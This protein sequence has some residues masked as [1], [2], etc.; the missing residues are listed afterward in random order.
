MNTMLLKLPAVKG[1]REGRPEACPHCGGGLLQGWGRYSKAVRDSQ[2]RTVETRRY[3]CLG[4]G[5]TFRTY[6][7]GISAADQS[8]RLVQLAA[9]MWSLGLSLR[10]TVAILGA[11]GVRLGRMSVWRDGQAIAAGLG[12]Q[13]QQRLVP[14]LGVDG[15]WVSLQGKRQGVVV[16]VDLGSGEPLAL[17]VL[18]ENDAQAVSRW[19]EEV[20]MPLG[21]EVLVTD[22]LSSYR[23]VARQLEWEQQICYFHL[24][25]WVG[26]RLR[27][28]RQ[29]LDSAWYAVLDEIAELLKTL[30]TDGGQ[31]LYEL[32]LQIPAQHP[33]AGDAPAPLWRLRDMLIRLSNSW[34][35]YAL[36]RRRPGVPATNNRTEQAI[37]KLK[38]R[39]HAIR[40]Y[41]STAGLQTMFQL[42]GA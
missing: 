11:F 21:V 31:R 22:D 33:R 8:A 39:S 6:P 28:L 29:L 16:A 10:Q 7:E 41:K 38:M 27:E 37:G 24:R 35:A 40:G 34:N 26:R 36:F 9:L 4:C 19:L 3:R 1:Q 30:P 15:T 18:E 20:V 25:R 12:A 23:E 17:G 42:A 2:V 13:R 5:R 14:Y 32:W